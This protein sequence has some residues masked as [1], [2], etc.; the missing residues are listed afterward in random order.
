M[1][2]NNLKR[3]YLRVFQP[4]SSVPLGYLSLTENHRASYHCN[5][6]FV[7]RGY[8]DFLESVVFDRFS[9]H[10]VMSSQ[11]NADSLIS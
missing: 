5:L 9:I 1:N 10:R 6:Y 8:E 3:E 4:C 7:L 2:K 11:G